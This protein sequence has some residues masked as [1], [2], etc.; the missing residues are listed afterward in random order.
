[1]DYTTLKLAELKSFV[2]EQGIVIEGDRRLKATYLQAIAA[3]EAAKAAKAEVHAAVEPVKTQVETVM[4]SETAVAVAKTIWNGSWQA[5][6]LLLWFGVVVFWLGQQ[7]RKEYDRR[8]AARVQRF[9]A[10]SREY[11]LG[12]GGQALEGDDHRN[13]DNAH[14]L[15]ESTP[16][17]V[18]V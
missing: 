17:R 10:Q 18:R 2:A 9:Y 3:W 11:L 1:M 13:D 15:P 16:V 8:Y 14:R 4:T 7:W 6:E 5:L 12:R